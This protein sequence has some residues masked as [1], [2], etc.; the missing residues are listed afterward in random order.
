MQPRQMRVTFRPVRPRLTVCI[1]KPR[2]RVA[3]SSFVDRDL[4]GLDYR[5][6]EELLGHRDERR[7]GLFR[8]GLGDLN[9]E[10]LALADGGDLAEAKRRQGPLDGLALGIENAVLEPDRDAGLHR[11]RGYCTST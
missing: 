4:V 5:V 10:D 3:R 7:F 1:V 2:F 6:G 9:I 8:V 11:A